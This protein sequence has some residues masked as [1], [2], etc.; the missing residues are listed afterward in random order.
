ML[1]PE[2]IRGRGREDKEMMKRE[3]KRERDASK[4]G[5][6]SQGARA[7]VSWLDASAR[8]LTGAEL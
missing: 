1:A 8:V 4:R 2:R 6:P 7:L 3:D 5:M